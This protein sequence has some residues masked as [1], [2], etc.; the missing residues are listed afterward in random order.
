M[1]L[2]CILFMWRGWVNIYVYFINNDYT[3]YFSWVRVLHKYFS[4]YLHFS[5][6][7]KLNMVYDI[8]FFT[9][10]CFILF[11]L[12]FITLLVLDTFKIPVSELKQDI[13]LFEFLEWISVNYP[14]FLTSI[15]FNLFLLL[16]IILVVLNTTEIPVPTQ[17]ILW[18]SLSLMKH[19]Q[20]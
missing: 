12:L 10:I 11:F 3:F 9:N 14:S 20:L 19:Y 8:N 7:I 17:K 1:T 13:I 16:F 2:C 6:K 15:S 5:Q 4:I 18:Y